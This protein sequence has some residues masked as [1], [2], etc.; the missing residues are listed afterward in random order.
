VRLRRYVRRSSAVIQKLSRRPGKG[1]RGVLSYCLEASKQPEIVAGNMVGEDA[2]SL[3][4][5]FADARAANEA[6]RKPVFHASLS[7]DASDQLTP[8]MWR[9]IAEAYVDRMGYG[10]SLWVAIR[11]RD[12]E[13][14]HI[15]VIASRV[16]FDG[17]RVAD[18]RERMRGEA[19]VRQLEQ[20]HGLRLVAPSREA[21]RVAVTRE[22][23]G[24]FHRTGL[25][26]AKARLQEH[27]ELAA[28]DRPTM[29]AF[30]ERLQAQG[31]GIRLHVASTG[32]VFGISF[33][34]DGIAFKGSA[35]GRGYSW[36]GLQEHKG[37]SFDPKR[38]LA[39]LLALRAP[40]VL[41]P[42]PGREDLSAPP[43]PMPRQRRPAEVY[44]TA[45][46]LTSCIE[47]HERI[48]AVG[49]L[50]RA[51]GRLVH[52][53]EAVFN[54]RR[55]AERSL[56]AREA[57]L[58]DQVSRIFE[59]PD[60]AADRLRQIIRSKGHELAGRALVGDPGTFGRL[61]GVGVSRLMSQARKDAL[62][63]CEQL[64]AELRQVGI[65]YARLQEKAGQESHP[66]TTQA[67]AEERANA[68]HELAQRLPDPSELHGQIA[69]AAERLGE[70]TVRRMKFSL[71]QARAIF[72]A[73]ESA[74]RLRR[75]LQSPGDDPEEKERGL[76]R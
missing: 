62:F 69:Q 25:V 61:R 13:N 4:R 63:L 12:T 20:E 51:A 15:H 29:T 72:A 21:S 28:R 9:E 70:G 49:A 33:E 2:R 68:L 45:A 58:L 37:I 48:A 44:R 60:S 36:R 19:I 17:R 73:L 1:F 18:H 10:D 5:E 38:D 52:D 65:E 55:R 30:A 31:V 7:V 74:R 53:A 56:V 14:D 43:A 16:G 71:W 6:V 42:A 3:A 46:N 75:Y 22:E 54:E 47:V 8:E 11:H 64:G 35:L 76:Y 27:L 24:A 23:L 32:R 41:R 57:R 66:E 26:N 67:L 39:S 34:L 59:E 50:Q 40:D